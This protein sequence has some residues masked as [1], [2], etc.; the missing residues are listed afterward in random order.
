VADR[1]FSATIESALSAHEVNAAFA[2]YLDWSGGAVRMW[3]GNKSISWS[4]QTWVGAGK[5][6][7]LDKLV[8]S[9]DRSD[10]GI[11]LTLNYL[12]DTLRNE[13]VTNNS[14]GRA[15]SV[16]FWIM[17][18]ATG[19]VTDGYEFFTGFIDRCEIEDAGTTGRIIV[20]LASELAKLQRPRFFT[21]SDAHQKFLFSGDKGCEFATKMD[22]VILWG[23]NPFAPAPPRGR[24][25][26]PP[27]NPNSPYPPGHH[28][29][30]PGLVPDDQGHLP[31]S[32][33]YTPTYGPKP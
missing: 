30:D 22:E 8:D 5:F 10:V 17:N 16:Y 12:D 13:V 7:A 14:V 15:A 11:E 6:G 21:L 20:R 1:G 28:Y 33:W 24:F 4:S 32:H 19:A 18:I 3:S 9:V 2:V 25:E 23:R 27:V 29:Y 31:G 26:T